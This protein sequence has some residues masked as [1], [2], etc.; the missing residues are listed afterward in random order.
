MS[1]LHQLFKQ[2]ET[3]ENQ[4]IFFEIGDSKFHLRRFGG[5]NRMR[6]KKAFAKYYKP[7]AKQIELEVIDPELERE[8]FVKIFVDSCL[9]SW[10]N[11]NDAQ[12]NTL[13]YSQENAVKLFTELPELFD[14]LVEYTKASEHFKE[15]LG[16]F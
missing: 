12:G 9:I 8:I 3:L 16:N 5:A 6:V 10:E 14:V 11:V 7:Y 2:N 1:N 4:G 15:D 13:S